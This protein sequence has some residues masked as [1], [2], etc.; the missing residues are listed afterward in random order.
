MLRLATPNIFPFF[1]L[2][3]QQKIITTYTFP[4][5]DES[6]NSCDSFLCG[7]LMFHIFGFGV[8]SLVFR[9]KTTSIDV[10]V[11][12]PW[13]K[14]AP[15]KLMSTLLADHVR[16]SAVLFDRGAALRTFLG[17]FVQPTKILFI[18]S[19]IEQAK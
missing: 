11:L 13:A 2:K 3:H 18:F 4:F 1:L 6:L 19:F 8:S 9:T 5:R 10:V 14:A 12:K 7:W 15:A 17:V 16:A